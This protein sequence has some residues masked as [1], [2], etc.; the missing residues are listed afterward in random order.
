MSCHESIL[1]WSVGKRFPRRWKYIDNEMEYLYNSMINASCYLIWIHPGTPNSIKPVRLEES[2]IME[3]DN[4]NFFQAIAVLMIRPPPHIPDNCGCS[5]HIIWHIYTQSFFYWRH[6]SHITAWK[7]LHT[8]NFCMGIQWL[9]MSKL[10]E[11][12]GYIFSRIYALI[13]I[14]PYWV[15]EPSRNCFP[16]E[17]RITSYSE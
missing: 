9:I 1:K 15:M 12:I 8:I 10:Q 6:W 7:E 4:A 16:G 13:S 11:L 2:H 5:Q 14:K 17:L 3:D